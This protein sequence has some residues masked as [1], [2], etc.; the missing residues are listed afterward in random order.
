[1]AT[2]AARR[3]SLRN[4]LFTAERET[5][6]SAVTGDYVNVDFIDEHTSSGHRMSRL[7]FNRRSIYRP[8]AGRAG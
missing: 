5:T 8:R 4:E 6:V 1:M 3:T 7:R 2:V